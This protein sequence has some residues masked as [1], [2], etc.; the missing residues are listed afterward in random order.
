MWIDKVRFIPV[1]NFATMFYYASNSLRYPGKIARFAK[2]T[3]TAVGCTFLAG[4][5]ATIFLWAPVWVNGVIIAGFIYGTPV[6]VT[7]SIRADVQQRKLM[8]SRK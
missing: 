1:I 2:M 6:A 5:I 4:V 7:Y 8:A 3:F